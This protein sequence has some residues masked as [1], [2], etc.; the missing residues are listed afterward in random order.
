MWCRA[1]LFDFV[2]RCIGPKKILRV[3]CLG[4]NGIALPAITEFR[5]LKLFLESKISAFSSLGLVRGVHSFKVV[6]RTGKLGC[7][8]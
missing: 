7:F 6:L 4:V 5:T 3:D 8:S 2:K 1:G